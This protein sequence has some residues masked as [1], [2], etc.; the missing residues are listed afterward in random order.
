MSDRIRSSSTRSV[1]SPNYLT[2]VS[3][4]GRRIE[5]IHRWDTKRNKEDVGCKVILIDE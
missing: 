3:N 1:L 4:P 2:P 5:E